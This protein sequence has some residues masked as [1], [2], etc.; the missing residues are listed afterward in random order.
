MCRE[1]EPCYSAQVI[2]C[3]VLD[4]LVQLNEYYIDS[5]LSL[6]EFW[7]SEG[8]PFGDPLWLE[9][10]TIGTAPDSYLA[11]FYQLPFYNTD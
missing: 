7:I 4:Q 3:L 2:P 1:E 9:I 6:E 11:G 8:D 10:E 5:E